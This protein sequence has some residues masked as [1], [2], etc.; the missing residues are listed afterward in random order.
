MLIWGVDGMGDG[1]ILGEI[2]MG[3][4]MI[5]ELG[6]G[7]KDRMER[8]GVWSVRKGVMYESDVAGNTLRVSLS[9]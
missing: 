6:R 7:Y 3:I 2:G 5:M 4:C 8:N 1:E 9:R